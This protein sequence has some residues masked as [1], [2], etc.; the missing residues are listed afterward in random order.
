MTPAC[1][2]QNLQLCS[3]HGV[4]GYDSDDKRAKCFCNPGYEGELC[5]QGAPITQMV[6]VSCLLM[7]L[8]FATPTVATKPGV[9]GVAVVL[10]FVCI[11]LA[12][13]LGVLYVTPTPRQATVLGSQAHSRHA[14]GVFFCASSIYLWVKIK[15]LRLDTSAY[16]TLQVCPSILLHVSSVIHGLCTHTHGSNERLHMI[17]Q[18]GPEAEGDAEL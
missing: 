7:M 15:T 18:G 16:K 8:T 12:L 4:C 6:L 13:V 11:V 3:A 9:D 5:E 1:W 10:V 2:G 17:D 14:F